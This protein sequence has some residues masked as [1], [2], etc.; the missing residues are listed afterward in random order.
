MINEMRSRL[1]IERSQKVFNLLA[2]MLRMGGESN[3]GRLEFLD[4]S[5]LAENLMQTSP[6][7]LEHLSTAAFKVLSEKIK[8]PNLFFQQ[9]DDNFLVI[10]V[11]T[12][13]ETAK[14]VS[15][16][17]A[18][19]ILDVL[20]H[21]YGV[22]GFEAHILVKQLDLDDVLEL[23][24]QFAERAAGAL[25][26]TEPGASPAPASGDANGP[27]ARMTFQPMWRASK[28]LVG[29]YLASPKATMPDGQVKRGHGVLE[30]ITDLRGLASFDQ[31]N[32]LSAARA[33]EAGIDAGEKFLLIVPISMKAYQQASL[34]PFY[35]KT[36]DGLA[37]GV[38]KRL[39]VQATGISPR[40]N[41]R[42]LGLNINVLSSV[43]ESVVA[44]LPINAG[45]VAGLLNA[46]LGAV[47]ASAVD[48]PNAGSLPIGVSLENF[49]RATR[50]YEAP[51]YLTDVED[52]AIA[53]RAASLGFE[54]LSGA[55]VG[56]DLL[57]PT[58][59]TLAKFE[60]LAARFSAAA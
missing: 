44:D 47:G 41:A 7:K 59:A 60:E 45:G 53:S 1:D 37:P 39:S 51:L 30:S 31:A 16:A 14:R 57:K 36:L 38:L 15:A 23:S 4:V 6:E 50:S 28:N 58:S 18:D 2:E 56:A 13:E 42:Q 48:R 29:V 34:M 3:M 21:E 19:A 33:I 10:F 20:K 55:F 22:E 12:D 24:Q 25:A 54:Y 5:A 11:G 49:V 27:K 43:C 46:R 40:M 35:R 17:C 9:D 26:P 32:I 52:E 8:D